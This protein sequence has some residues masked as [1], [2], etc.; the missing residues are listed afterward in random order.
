MLTD[1]QFIE[2]V[3]VELHDGMEV[4]KP[5]HELLDAIEALTPNNGRRPDGSRLRPDP[6]AGPQQARASALGAVAHVTVH[7]GARDQRRWRVRVRRLGAAVPVLAGVIVVVVIAAVAL[8]SVSHRHP[9]TPVGPA[10]AA[11]NGKVAFI[12]FG[13]GGYPPTRSEHG[14]M[15]AFDAVG[16]TNP[17]GSGRQN[18]GLTGARRRGLRAGSIRSPGRP[19]GRRSRISRGTRPG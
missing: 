8:T 16:V 10:A 1:E 18:V 19:T 17:D 2:Q 6:G 13:S 3:R 12:A 4:L 11:R 14:V 7:R 5:S 9:S 15:W